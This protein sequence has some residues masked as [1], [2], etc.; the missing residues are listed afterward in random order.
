MPDVKSFGIMLAAHLQIRV[1]NRVELASSEIFRM[2]E[3]GSTSVAS[4][5]NVEPEED[6]AIKL[7]SSLFILND[8]LFNQVRE[9][10]LE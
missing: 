4:G 3:Q 5:R 2:L 1:Y 6:S 9:A 10:H 7:L 8:L